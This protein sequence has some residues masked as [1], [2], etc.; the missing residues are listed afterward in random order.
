[1]PKVLFIL[2]QSFLKTIA[3][4]IKHVFTN[5]DWNKECVI[6]IFG[7]ILREQE[8]CSQFHAGEDLKNTNQ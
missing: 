6:F 8:A 3:C 4:L 7:E 2:N 1:M 5:I